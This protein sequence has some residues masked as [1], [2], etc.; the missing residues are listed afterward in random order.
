MLIF[1]FKKWS[2]FDTLNLTLPPGSPPPKDFHYIKHSRYCQP[3]ALYRDPE[4]AVA[5]TRVS[6]VAL[7]VHLFNDPIHAL[8][9][10]AKT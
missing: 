10:N 3:V 9:R 6:T 4:M 1:I 5:A 8:S 2:V 7:F